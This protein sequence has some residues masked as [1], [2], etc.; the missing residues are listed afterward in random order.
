MVTK[1][2]LPTWLRVWQGGR[3]EQLGTA[4]QA[5]VT[6]ETPVHKPQL[7]QTLGSITA[8]STGLTLRT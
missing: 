2:L 5:Y 4:L 7:L 6:K 1:M 3:S 8:Q